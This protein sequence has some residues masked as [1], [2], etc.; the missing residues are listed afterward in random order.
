VI[1]LARN[2]LK[3]IPSY[4]SLLHYTWRVLGDPPPEDATGRDF[5]LRMAHHWY[6]YPLERLA[7][8]PSDQYAI[9]RFS[10]MVHDPAKTVSA[11]YRRFGLEVSPAFARELREATE[12]SRDYTSEHD[13]SLQQFGLTREEILRQFGDVFEDFGFDYDGQGKGGALGAARQRASARERRAR[14]PKLRRRRA[15]GSLQDG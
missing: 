8:A 1:Y 12:R 6:R 11:I 15:L 4:I 7:A 9:V 5:V 3:V 13:Y 2:P 14:R 10:A